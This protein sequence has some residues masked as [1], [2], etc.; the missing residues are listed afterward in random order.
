MHLKKSGFTYSACGPFTNHGERIQKIRETGD[1]NHLYRN[2]LD[3]A[4]SAHDT[5]YSDS[6]A[7]KTAVNPKYNEYQGWLASMVYEFF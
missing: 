4:F 3:K 6:K 7:Y 2:E 5:T 1:L